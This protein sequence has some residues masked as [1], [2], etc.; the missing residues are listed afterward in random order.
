[1]QKKEVQ[2]HLEI[3]HSHRR[4]RRLRQSAN[5]RSLVQEFSLKKDD[6]IVP[7]FINEPPKPTEVIPSLPGISR[8]AF[9]D[10]EE[11]VA[12]LVS[13][14]TKAVMLFP[15]I[16]KE[17]KDPRGKEAL[18]PKGLMPESIRLLKKCF[19]ELLVFAD[20][21]LDPYTSHGHD[22]V[23]DTHG[24]VLNDET[25]TILAEQSL[26]LAMAGVDFVAPSDMMD[27]RIGAIRSQLDNHGY[28][29]TG[30]LAYSAKY[31][32]AFYGP[33]REAVQ[34]G[35]R[36]LD[37]KTYQLSPENAQQGLLE[38]QFDS[39]EGA[40]LLM[41]KPGLPYLDILYRIK[42]KSMIPLVVY[43]VSGEYALLKAGVEKNL[44]DEKSAVY[45][46]L[47]A[48]KRAGADLIVTYYAQWALENLF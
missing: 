20:I 2:P 33:F 42:E 17:K 47:I 18:N 23:I 35:T 27:G 10:L 13:L 24:Y 19:P 14:G 36:G 3:G 32:S 8:I 5:I 34:S 48:F 21:A 41:V 30:I 9:S 28:Q 16:S 45:E 4:L 15:V 6:F 7:I 46:T 38:A 11:H 26:N 22:G 1:M 12:L 31:H 44:I 37:K 43:H 40:D 29:K 39:A 25:V